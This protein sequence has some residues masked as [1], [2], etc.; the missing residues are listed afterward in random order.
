MLQRAKIN[1]WV[2]ANTRQS[3]FGGFLVMLPERLAGLSIPSNEGPHMA[4]F[5]VPFRMHKSGWVMLGMCCLLGAF[6]SGWRVGIVE[7]VLV[8]ASL[9]LHEVGHM[10]A[11]TVLGIPVREFG[12][13]W[14]GAYNRRA[15]ANRRRDE[16]LISFAGP[17]TNLFLALPMMFV[18]VIG[19]Q[20]ALCNILLCV[21]NLLP[22]PSSDGLR[23]LRNIRSSTPVGAPIPAQPGVVSQKST[24]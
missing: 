9:L 21:V 13:A 4:R 1:S 5:I 22:I 15:Y 14:R 2:L 7:G 24:A 8:I 18:P 10:T 20:L 19:T 16:I 3:K 6:L 12:L 17:L 23:I 11:A